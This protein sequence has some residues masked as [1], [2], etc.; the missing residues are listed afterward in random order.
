MCTVENLSQ[1]VFSVLLAPLHIGTLVLD[2]APS[3][4]ENTWTP[5]NIGGRFWRET[6]ENTFHAFTIT[7]EQD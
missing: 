1:L 6:Y 3:D 2:A 4:A 7:H 5:V